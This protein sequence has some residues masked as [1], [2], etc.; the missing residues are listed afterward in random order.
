MDVFRKLITALRWAAV[1]RGEAV[2]DANVFRIVAQEHRDAEA[3]LRQAKCDLVAVMAEEVAARRRLTEL[4]EMIAQREGQARAALAKGDEALA[5]MLAERVANHARDEAQQHQTTERL[6][7]RVERLRLAVSDLEQRLGELARRLKL[8]RATASVQRA[9]EMVRTGAAS[10]L[11]AIGE[12]EATLNRIEEMQ[13]AREARLEAVEE[14][15]HPTAERRLDDALA[16]AGLAAPALP[17]VES[18]LAR[19][20][21]EAATQAT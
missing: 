13:E 11:S 18:I 15:S 14:I 20:R 2:V 9:E 10:G 16:K 8:A 5:R 3:A 12:A 4:R 7:E 17:T 6:R 1:E 19:L 21:G